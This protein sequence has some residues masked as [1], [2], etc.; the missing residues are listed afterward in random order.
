MPGR[1]F[2][3]PV[4]AL[5]AIIDGRDGATMPLGHAPGPFVTLR[6]NFAR[7]PRSFADAESHKTAAGRAGT[8]GRAIAAKTWTQVWTRQGEVLADRGWG[9]F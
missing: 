5:P 6:D 1:R 3:R 2:S 7:P 9:A 8:E 4:R